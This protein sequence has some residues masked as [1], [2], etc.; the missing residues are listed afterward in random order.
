[1][2][3]RRFR[4]WRQSGPQLGDAVAPIDPFSSEHAWHAS[5]IDAVDARAT[6]WEGIWQKDEDN[7]HNVYIAIENLVA[8]CRG[9]HGVREGGLQQNKHR[10]I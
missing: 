3:Q 8:E 2:A 4:Q 10:H 1:M 6:K 9:G 5:P 7:K